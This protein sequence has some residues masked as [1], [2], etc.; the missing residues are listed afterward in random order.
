MAGHIDELLTL[1]AAL[2][3]CSTQ[4]YTCMPCCG[5]QHAVD[6]GLCAAANGQG[7]ARSVV[8]Q[9]LWLGSVKIWMPG[10]LNGKSIRDE[11]MHGKFKN[12]IFV[13]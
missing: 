10:G 9:M 8:L 1:K 12:S 11:E 6:I 5:A 3:H 2:V 7:S 4:C 13:R